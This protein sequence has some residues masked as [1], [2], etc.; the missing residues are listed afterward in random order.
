MGRGLRE[1]L[2][3]SEQRSSGQC[4]FRFHARPESAA[5]YKVSDRSKASH[6]LPQIF[7]HLK[8]VYKILVAW[9]R[10]CGLPPKVSLRMHR[11]CACA[12]RAGRGLLFAVKFV[13]Q[14]KH[15]VG[16]AALCGLGGEGY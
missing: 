10:A 15:R 11:P 14:G 9:G 6:C 4:R 1:S 16:L 7:R 3:Q 12:G 5:S 2:G 13:A 8:S